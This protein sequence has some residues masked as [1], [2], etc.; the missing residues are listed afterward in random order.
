MTFREPFVNAGLA[1]IVVVAACGAASA[2]EAAKTH[3][4]VAKVVAIDLQANSI[5]IH[6]DAGPSQ[7]FPVVGKAIEH[8]DE[9]A[10]GGMFKLTVQDA[11]GEAKEA[12]IAI[13]PAKKASQ[14]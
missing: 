10:V 7:S 11:D 1:A 5:R 13:K 9:I 14:I 8:L 2:G 6:V 3:Q 12:V 4:I